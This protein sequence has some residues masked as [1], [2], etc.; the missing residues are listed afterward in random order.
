M[1][2]TQIYIILLFVF[3]MMIRLTGTSGAFNKSQLFRWIITVVLI[4]IATFRSSEMADY[5]NYSRAFK[6][7]GDLRFEPAF[8]VIR[9]LARIS[10]NPA[11]FGFFL[12][13]LVSVCAKV[14]A[15]RKFKVPFIDAVLVYLT[16]IYV[17]QDLVAIRSG[18]AAS[19]LLLALHYRRSS[20]IKSIFCFVVACTFHLSALLFILIYILSYDKLNRLL[21]VLLIIASYG[22]Y[23]LDVEFVND[24]IEH[25]YSS[26]TLDLL[27]YTVNEINALNL[28]QI[29]HTIVCIMIWIRIRRIEPVNKEVLILLKLYTVAVCA[30]PLLSDYIQIAVRTSELFYTV[31]FLLL[32]LA[33]N[34][35]F[36]HRLTNNILFVVYSLVMFYIVV[37]DWA[38]WNPSL[39]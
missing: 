17:A 15:I 2:H 4:L 27:T 14:K 33:F 26:T 29:G 36:K 8:L 6:Y 35:M 38:Y 16:Y 31:E 3:L 21:Y 37:T 28:L 23:I 7:V 30:L 34:H 10:E 39:L 18:A 13:A 24:I 20:L 9:A 11:I 5:S 19:V 22:Y 1:E 25:F 12:F 32:P